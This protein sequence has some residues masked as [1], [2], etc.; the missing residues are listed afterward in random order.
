MP[1]S[2]APGWLGAGPSAEHAQLIQ[3]A[4]R[5]ATL[6][7]VTLFRTGVPAAAEL[8]LSHT[9]HPEVSAAI[10]AAPGISSWAVAVGDGFAHAEVVGVLNA[11]VQADEYEQLLASIYLN[12]NWKH[13]SK[14]L[15][16]D[17]KELFARSVE[18]ASD[19]SVHG[20]RWWLQ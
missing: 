14:Q 9:L 3:P 7:R 20:L 19:G 6:F 15:T 12:I 1:D 5:P 13:V 10:A 17:Q 16:A 4:S 11:E 2:I 18:R 8:H